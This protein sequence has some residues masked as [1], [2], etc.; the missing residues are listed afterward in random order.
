M[1]TSKIKKGDLVKIIA[2]KDNGKEGKVLS[3]NTKN[4]KVIVEGVN[5]V[6]KHSKPNYQNQQGG[7]IEK[8]APIDMSNVMYLYKGKPVRV[9]FK[10]EGK[11]K[12][13]VAKVGGKLEAID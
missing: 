5:K 8:E 12:K 3:V 10:G 1:A 11:D 4:N 9:G 2:G 13:R 7:I 6:F